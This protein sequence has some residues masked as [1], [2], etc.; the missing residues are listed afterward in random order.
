MKWTL[1]AVLGAA[2]LLQGI[3]ASCIAQQRPLASILPAQ[4]WSSGY[5]VKAA[6][7]VPTV[8]SRPCSMK[9]ILGLAALVTRQKA[10]SCCRFFLFGTLKA[11][12][13]PKNPFLSAST[14]G[15]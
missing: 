3:G 8:T 11:K 10:S 14:P 15:P 4:R 2:A 13:K 5:L 12:C 9:A 7:R 1:A 6:C